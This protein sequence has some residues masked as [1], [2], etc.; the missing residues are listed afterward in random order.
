MTWG[1]YGTSI[2]EQLEK[3]LIGV[4]TIYSTKDAFAAKLKDGNVVAWGNR[5]TGG[6]ADYVQGQLPFG[7][8]GAWLR[9]GRSGGG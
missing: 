4:D 7:W 3:K 5:M 8:T 2:D 1:T 6:N 9:G